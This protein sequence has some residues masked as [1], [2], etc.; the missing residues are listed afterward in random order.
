[1][2]KTDYV[3]AT[4]LLETDGDIESAAEALATEQSTGTWT[5][6]PGEEEAR[7]RHG[8]RVLAVTPKGERDRP[9]L[10]TRLAPE[11]PGTQ[12]Y[13][14]GI[15]E[16]AFPHINFG[17]RLPNL[18]SAVAGNLFEM[19]AFTAAKLIDLEFPD[20]FLSHFPGPKFGIEGTR[21]VLGVYDRP[22]VGAIVKPC[23]GLGPRELAEIVYRAARGGLDFIKD[24]ELLADPSYNRLHDR[25]DAVMDALGRAERETG[26]KTMYAFNVTD[27][28]DRILELHD[29]VVRGGGNC[30][31]LNYVTAGIDALRMLAEHTEVP[32]HAHRDFFP[33]FA[34][35]PWLGLGTTVFTTL[36]RIAGADQ[37][38]IGALAGK[39]YETDEEVLESVAACR[40]RLGGLR[41]SMPVSSGGQHAGKVP[42]TRRK[43][44]HP[45]YLHLSGGGVFGHPDGPEA[46]ARS[47]R[48][49]LA[50]TAE[51]RKLE[52][53]ARDQAELRR[54]IDYFGEIL[55]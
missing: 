41:Q 35:S 55:Y 1:M 2:K 28:V 47:I 20:E 26:E 11:A 8:A 40:A 24:D 37:L 54:A 9:S 44:A 34:R 19:G 17:P 48:Q 32:I 3:I 36:S 13:V 15:V 5:D 38:H 6:V 21:K 30:V 43:M 29:I 25:V 45:D 18:L 27:R 42:I 23:V 31:M 49:A 51:G 39:L 16:V 10:P 12:R 22:L 46:G 4:Y 53:A 50:A 33:A 14:W 52:D 7:S